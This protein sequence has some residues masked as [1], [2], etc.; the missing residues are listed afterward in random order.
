MADSKTNRSGK[1]D[2]ATK[3]TGCPGCDSGFEFLTLR[4]F[5]SRREFI[6]TAATATGVAA[7][8]ALGLPAVVHAAE[9]VGSAGEAAAANGVTAKGAPETLVKQLYDSLKPEQAKVVAFDWDYV[10]PKRGLLRTR[11][12]NNWNITDQ[13]IASDFYT[14]DQQEMIRAIYEG[15]FQPDWMPKIDQAA[16]GRWQGLRQVAKHRHVRQSG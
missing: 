1:S 11:V 14:K 12:A 8:G 3:S 4:E 5:F 13:M 6:K 16:Q 9:A 10:D 15:L 7:V 2:E